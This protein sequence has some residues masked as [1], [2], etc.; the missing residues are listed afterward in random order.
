M[1]SMFEG[2]ESFNQNLGDWDLSSIG[3]AAFGGMNRMLSGA[4]VSTENYDAT[5][6]GW[7]ILD[8]VSGETQ[9]P[10]SITLDGG[11][12][13]FCLSEA[14]RQSLIDDFGWTITDGG[15]AADCQEPNDFAL[16]I[17][18][19]GVGV[20]YNGETFV[21][22]TYFNTGRTLDRPQT[23]LPE[24]Y[25]TFRYS[26]SQQM[27]Y[28]IPIPDGEYTV[29]LYFAE[30]WFGATAGGAGGVGN[31]I[32]DVNIEGA[33]AEDNLDIFAEVGADAMLMKTYNVTVNGGILDIDF[34]S[35][36]VVGGERHP[37]INAIEILGQNRGGS[38]LSGK[39]TISNPSMVSPNP[40]ISITTLSFEKPIEL[41]TIQVFD[42]LGRLVHS[43]NGPE[44]K[45]E[46]SYVLQVNH[47][48]AGSY[49][50]N[51]LDV[52]GIKHQ[53]QIVIKK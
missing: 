1:D 17:N 52:N 20:E 22:D 27:S 33:L 2:A 10:M 4:N 53:K 12:S 39:T 21:G 40:A 15:R 28:D 36:D 26:R 42:V 49:F 34:D 44:V 16:R 43:Y 11:N 5:L 13:Q 32:F 6:I 47:L 50:I 30:L 35:R 37:V 9:I 23:G 24:P 48:E 41:T 14:A 25:Q 8:P 46:G 29:N 7:S 19:G 31:R 51:S 38:G 18:T 3:T 45:D